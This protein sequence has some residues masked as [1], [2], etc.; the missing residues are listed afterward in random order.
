M[1]R[2]AKIRA[3][4]LCWVMGLV[5]SGFSWRLIY[6]QIQQHAKYTALANQKQIYRRIIPAH[7]GSIMDIYGEVLANDLPLCRVIADASHFKPDT[8][9]QVA[10]LLADSLALD[11]K[12]LAEKLTDCQKNNRR[13]LVIKRQVPEQTGDEIKAGSPNK[14]SGASISSPTRPASI[15]TVPCSATSS[16]LPISPGRGCRVWRRA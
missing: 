2:T 11:E 16:V 4:T 9:P 13:Y 5:F 6:I 8:L 3:L 12:S 1:I 7:R 15:Q 10:H 14:N